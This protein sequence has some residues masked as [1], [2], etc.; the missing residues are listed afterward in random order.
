MTRALFLFLLAPVLMITGA[1]AKKARP[2][3]QSPAPAALFR[4]HTIADAAHRCVQ[5]RIERLRGGGTETTTI[6]DPEDAAFLRL[7]AA[8]NAFVAIVPE[9]PARHRVLPATIGLDVRLG[10]VSAATRAVWSPPRP[11]PFDL[12]AGRADL[13]AE[14]ERAVAAGRSVVFAAPDGFTITDA[15]AIDRADALRMLGMRPG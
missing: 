5:A 10:P 11:A 6:C 14:I 12:P 3:T 7:M 4:I 13:T 9:G 2:V 8:K 15:V 1:T